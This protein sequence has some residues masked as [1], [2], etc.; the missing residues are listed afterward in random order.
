MDRIRLLFVALALLVSMPA[1]AD[2]VSVS[3]IKLV[4]A[5]NQ[6]VIRHEWTGAATDSTAY[7]ISSCTGRVEVRF[8]P[9]VSDASADALVEFRLCRNSSDTWQRC[10]AIPYAGPG[11]GTTWTPINALTSGEN[12]VLA[13]ATG[14]TSGGDTARAEVRCTGQSSLRSDAV[15][16]N[17]DADNDGMYEAAY[18]WDAD[19]DGSGKVTC[20]AKDAPDPA[21]KV[22]GEV[23]YRDLADDLNCAVHGCGNGQMERNGSLYLEEGVVYVNFPC[24]DAREPTGFNDPTATNDNL[25]DA[26]SDTAYGHCPASPDGAGRRMATI[27]LMDW[28]G[29]IIGGGTDTRNPATTGS[30]KRDQGTY[31]V[32]DRGPNW[33]VGAQNG[34]NTWFGQPGFIRGITFGY[35]MGF[36]ATADATAPTGEFSGDGDSKG[37]GEI[38]GDQLVDA[39]N[40]SVCVADTSTGGTVSADGWAQALSPGD[41]VEI[42]GTTQT[43][44]FTSRIV[45]AAM[46]VRDTPAATTCNGAGTVSIPLGG[47]V[48]SGTASAYGADVPLITQVTDGFFVVASRS[49]FLDS[50][51][52]ITAVTIE[53]QDWWNE[54]GG[55][56]AGSGVWT[57]SGDGSQ[58]DFDCDTNPM[59]GMY[60]GG[61][62]ILDDV[63]I[64]H[65]HAYAIDGNSNAG[66]PLVRRPRFFYGNGGPIMDFGFGWNVEDVEVW[67]SQF[68]TDLAAAFGPGVVWR[69]L[70][71][72]NSS[73]LQI[74]TLSDHNNYNVIEDV[75]VYSSS[76]PRLFNLGCSARYNQIRNVRVSGYYGYGSTQGQ[77]SLVRLN[78]NSTST[79]IFSNTFEDMYIQGLGPGLAGTGGS[80]AAVVFDMDSAQGDENIGAIVRNVFNNIHFRY[81]GENSAYEACLFGVQDDEPVAGSGGTSRSIVPD[82]SLYD[83]LEDNY[84]TGSSVINV[85]G[86]P[87]LLYCG[88][89]VFDSGGDNANNVCDDAAIGPGG[90]GA[91]PRGCGN[92]EGNSTNAIEA[93]S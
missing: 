74:V 27:N 80:H 23:I 91:T 34:N 31:I 28:Q 63:V 51:A 16:G 22:A 45:I 21:C 66:N 4:E 5:A 47:I 49:N 56:C 76:F 59:V 29:E 3:D 14:A 6:S 70:K 2:W 32:D 15:G 7:D 11:D 88:C 60:G 12:Y 37:Y 71:V 39:M 46:R 30:Y 33:N 75:Q 84:F 44:T 90:G 82:F 52:R 43:D 89:G 73:F 25:R 78:C 53:P 19:A 42:Q 26:T 69:G 85:G 13:H 64:R 87:N 35:S 36:S 86:G 20:T 8:D 50:A 72:N 24:W 61:H 68:T 92:F 41:I 54:S 10:R 57:F 58:A 93:C 81:V 55:D 67:N 38:S 17:A 62:P 40:A 18:L 65:W 9:S 83:V 77:G 1:A 79:P 48:S